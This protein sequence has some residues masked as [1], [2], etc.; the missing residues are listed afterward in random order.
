MRMRSMGSGAHLK[1]R[2][3]SWEMNPI[4]NAMPR[5]GRGTLQLQFGWR[6]GPQFLA[7]LTEISEN[8]LLFLSPPLSDRASCD[9]EIQFRQCFECTLVN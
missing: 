9:V 1:V 3:V 8:E 5:R 4:L 2:M 7:V 6:N